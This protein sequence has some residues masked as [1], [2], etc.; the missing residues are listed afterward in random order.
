MSEFEDIPGG[1][2]AGDR[3]SSNVG[4]R[5]IIG[6]AV[7][8]LLGGLLIAAGNVVG[9]WFGDST[10][11][12]S[13]TA[14]ASAPPAATRTARPSPT[15]RALREFTLLPG[16]PPEQPVFDHQPTYWVE[17]FV[18]LPVRSGPADTAARIG[19]IQPGEVVLAAPP[20]PDNAIWFSIQDG[21]ELGG[22]IRVVDAGDEPLARYAPVAS[23]R[24]GGGISG[25]AAGPSGFVAHAWGPSDAFE[26]P[27]SFTL[28][29]ADGE[30]WAAAATSV[31]SNAGRW[32]SAWGPAGWLAAGTFDTEGGVSP[33]IWES[34]DGS[35][36]TPVGRLP[37]AGEGYVGGLVANASGYLLALGSSGEQSGALWFSPDGI[38]WQESAATGLSSN[39]DDWFFGP[40]GYG[41]LGT[42]SGF[43]AWNRAEGRPGPVEVA[44]SPGGRSW[45]VSRIGD[46]LVSLLTVA[47]I[48]DAV[49]A[50]GL[51]EDGRTHAWE[52]RV[53]DD[54]LVLAAAPAAELAFDGAV[55][56][57]LVADGEHAYAFGYERLGGARRGWTSGRSG[58]QALELPDGGF[59]AAPRVSAAG[60]AG[61]VVTGARASAVAV[62]P[63]LWHLR[64]DGRWWAVD[65]SPALPAISDPGLADC[66][67]PP[68]TAFEH[69]IIEA[70]VAVACFGDEPMTFVSWSASCGG[71]WEP[72]RRGPISSRWL[73]PNGPFF[74]LLPYEGTSDS[75]WWRQAVPH[76]D[77]G[78]RDKWA[79]TWLRVTGH[80][81][82]PA[83]GQCGGGPEAGS[84]AWWPGPEAEVLG[85]RWA[86]V[87]TEV[88]VL[89]RNH[90]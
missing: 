33:W 48:G 63:V 64:P 80:Y 72:S 39:F 40:G 83:A 71:C 16:E 88:E 15:E 32:M 28:Y 10:A 56:T 2:V 9:G 50:L 22:W 76:P 69:A 7:L 42:P 46:D 79:D 30:A 82:D 21:A 29:S 51:G 70:G 45:S 60:P 53:V 58:W 55:V 26:S 61:V 3:P 86:F 18:E 59:G 87:V 44:F 89:G 67:P 75:G 38:T 35:A 84:E 5:L 31:Q 12:G 11:A 25:I 68:T 54:G 52:G 6:L 78:W 49:V 57:S 17:A 20:E 13:P 36:W 73:P 23:G 47:V 43:L 14:V 1:T 8:A 34:S 65:G 66:P 41:L 74:V 77:L 81:D 37:V 19:R 4:D 27:H 24:Y 62:N 85:C 90:R